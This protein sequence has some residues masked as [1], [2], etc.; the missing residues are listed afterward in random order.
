MFLYADFVWGDGAV[1]AGLNR[2]AEGRDAV[3]MPVPPLV[4]EEFVA[5]ITRRA[6]ALIQ[7]HTD[8][9]GYISLA[10]RELI[11]LGKPIMH[12]IMRDSTVDYAC[13]TVNHAYILW[14]GPNDD[15]LMRCFH[16][17]PL[18]LR[19]QNENPEFFNPLRG[20]L[21]EDFVPRVLRAF[22]QIYCIRDSDEAAVVSLTPRHFCLPYLPAGQKIDADRVARWAESCAAPIHR[23]FFEEYSIWHS[24]RIEPDA[25]APVIARS[26]RVAAAVRSSLLMPDSVT[27]LENSAAWLA[28]SSRFVRFGTNGPTDVRPA[29]KAVSR[30]IAGLPPRRLAAEI[31]V[32]VAAWMP[33]DARHSIAR[34]VPNGWRSKIRDI[35][36]SANG[37]G[38]R[39]L[40]EEEVLSL[41]MADLKDLIVAFLLSAVWREKSPAFSRGLRKPS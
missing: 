21:D 30:V 41:S 2:I 12:P 14:L 17:H 19:V 29:R 40:R 8:N 31:V 4:A 15:Y 1:R 24:E 37:I 38:G 34:I 28:R 5:E 23:M 25:W 10:P 6:P 16:I 13:N 22:D 26:S 33:R 39:A 36:A 27:Q 9:V 3:V 18:A 35:R 32:R 11:R 20:T 7:F